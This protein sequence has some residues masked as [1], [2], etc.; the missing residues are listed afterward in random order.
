MTPQALALV[1]IAGLMHSA[2]NL[3]SKQSNDKQVFLWLAIISSLVIFL[4]PFILLYTPFPVIGWL[5]ILISG[6]LEAIYYL[7]LGAA[8]QHGDFSLVYPLAR[9]SAPLFV[10]FLALTLLGERSSLPGLLGILLIVCGIYVIHLKTFSKRG[11][12]VPFLSLREKSSWLALLVGLTIAS[13]STVDK[14]GLRFVNPLLYIYLIF[15]VSAL[16]LT[17][18]MLLIKR[19]AIKREWSMHKKGIFLAGALS[20]SAYLLVLLALRFSQV[21]YISSTREVSVVFAALL[22][23]SVLKE[24]FGVQ[25]IAGSLFIF[26]GILCIISTGL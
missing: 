25:K 6:A 19:R 8:Y 10:T 12:L 15:T 16:L 4:L 1:L 5:F 13:Y 3:F 14:V 7:L 26:A 11:W 21:S 9:G 17:P 24:T 20:L 2:W 22:G 23:A 18:Y